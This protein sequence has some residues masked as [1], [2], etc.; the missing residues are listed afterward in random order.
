[1]MSSEIYRSASQ[2]NECSVGQSGIVVLR[3]Q[4]PGQRG[5]LERTAD[6]AWRDISDAAIE[7][8]ARTL[9]DEDEQIKRIDAR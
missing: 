8:A 2:V 4:S 9:S 3:T 5:P 1:M 7:D 6:S